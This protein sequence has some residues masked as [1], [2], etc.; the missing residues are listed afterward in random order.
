MRDETGDWLYA[1]PADGLAARIAGWRR[2]ARLYAREA[3]KEIHDA[4]GMTRKRWR[5]P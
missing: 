3:A 2:S 1:S 5:A 4:D